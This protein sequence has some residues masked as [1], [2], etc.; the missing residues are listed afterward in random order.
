MANWNQPQCEA[1]WIEAEATW[2]DT[3][4]GKGGTLQLLTSIR[5][6]VRLK[7]PEIEQCAFCGKPTIFGVYRRADPSTVPFPS[8][9]EEG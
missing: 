9:S 1:C 2:V 4:D 5:S 8:E 3:S 7:D 6:P